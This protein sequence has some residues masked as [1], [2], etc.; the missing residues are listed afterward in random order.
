VVLGAQA[1]A[2]LRARRLAHARAVVVAFLRRHQAVP[3]D[4]A[5]ADRLARLVLRPV[6]RPVLRLVLRQRRLQG[7]ERRERGSDDEWRA[8]HGGVL[9]VRRSTHHA[10]P[11]AGA[12]FDPAQ[13]SGA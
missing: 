6:L 7:Q 11:P 13:E 4:V 8:F 3:V 5:V 12:A 1:L 9:C 10:A 2:F